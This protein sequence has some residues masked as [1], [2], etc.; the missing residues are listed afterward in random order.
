M[1]GGHEIEYGNKK[2]VGKTAIY[3]ITML[4]IEVAD[5]RWRGGGRP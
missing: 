5:V 2:V 1:V 3:S 4:S